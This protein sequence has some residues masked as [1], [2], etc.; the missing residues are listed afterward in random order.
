MHT[1]QE[2]VT[3]K[4]QLLKL[5]KCSEWTNTAVSGQGVWGPEDWF[6]LGNWKEWNIGRTVR[7]THSTHTQNLDHEGCTF[8]KILCIIS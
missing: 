5:Y 2:A 6:D 4:I 3:H 8:S 7:K 1:D